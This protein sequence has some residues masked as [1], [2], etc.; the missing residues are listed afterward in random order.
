M[1]ATFG[2]QKLLCYNYSTTIPIV[3]NIAGLESS[4]RYFQS[5]RSWRLLYSTTPRRICPHQLRVSVWCAS[6]TKSKEIHCYRHIFYL[7]EFVPHLSLCV[8]LLSFKPHACI[9]CFMQTL[10]R[11][12]QFDICFSSEWHENLAGHTCTRT[13]ASGRVETRSAS[14]TWMTHWPGE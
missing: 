4:M 8:T 14:L 2:K 3:D 11:H 6:L 13:H 12:H 5:S 10:V 1:L 7:M 9:H